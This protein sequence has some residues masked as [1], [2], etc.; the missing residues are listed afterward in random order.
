MSDW[1]Y[2]FMSADV[3]ASFGG[4]E[5]AVLALLVAF[6]IGHVVSWNYMLTHTGMS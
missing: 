3:P 5:S 2:T 1:L 6:C 4:A